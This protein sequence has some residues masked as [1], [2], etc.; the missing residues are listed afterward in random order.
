MPVATRK[1]RNISVGVISPLKSGIKNKPQRKRNGPQQQ[2]QTENLWDI[3]AGFVIPETAISVPLHE[4]RP[5]GRPKANKG[6]WSV[7]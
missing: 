1:N 6:W 4:N 7:E 3:L 2:Q 5:R